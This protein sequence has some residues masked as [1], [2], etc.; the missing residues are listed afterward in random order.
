MSFGCFS[1]AKSYHKLQAMEI[2]G[3]MINSQ[4]VQQQLQ[5]SCVRKHIFP[6][7]SGWHVDHLLLF[8]FGN[9]GRHTYCCCRLVCDGLMSTRCRY[10]PAAKHVHYP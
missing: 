10:G 8:G 9:A 4:D 2:L 6:Y 1:Y 7:F 3:D 5:V